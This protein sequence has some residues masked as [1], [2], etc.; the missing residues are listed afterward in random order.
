MQNNQIDEFQLLV[1]PVVVGKGK[2]LFPDGLDATFKLIETRPY[3][4]G[5]VLVRYQ[6]VP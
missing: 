3:D 5:V 6:V 2:C 1:Y 4:S